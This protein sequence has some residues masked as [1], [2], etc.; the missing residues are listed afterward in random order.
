[1]ELKSLLANL[2]QSSIISNQFNSVHTS[3]PYFSTVHFN[4][5]LSSMS[6]FS[7][8][9]SLSL[10]FSDIFSISPFPHTCYVSKASHPSQLHHTNNIRR[11]STNHEA[12]HYILPHLPVT[13]PL[14]GSNIFLRNLSSN[15]I[16]L[17]S[18]LWLRN[19]I[20][21]PYRTSKII[22]FC[23]TWWW[24]PRFSKIGDFFISWMTIKYQM[25]NFKY[26]IVNGNWIHKVKATLRENTK[27]IISYNLC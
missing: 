6:R 15:T 24:T 14:S 9:R 4:I 19:K 21:C 1:M 12:P 11:K 23:G 17:Y 7:P 20:S 18:S 5:I 25:N 16:N 2:Q 22:S 10:K 13:S 3:I 8:K 26:G 27:F